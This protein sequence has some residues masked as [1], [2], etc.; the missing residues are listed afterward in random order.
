MPSRDELTAQLEA[1]QGQLA[2]LDAN[3]YECE[4]VGEDGKRT[5]IGGKHAKSWL[6]QVGIIPADAPAGDGDGDGAGDGGGDDKPK[7]TGY[8]S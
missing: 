2:D 5:R 6:Q 8:F 1:L 3:D 4:V 7:K